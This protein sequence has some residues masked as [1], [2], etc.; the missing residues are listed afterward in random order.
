MEFEFFLE[1]P[2]V[3][4]LSADNKKT[5]VVRHLP[6]HVAQQKCWKNFS[7]RQIAHTT[8]NHVIAVW[9]Y[10]RFWQCLAFSH[11]GHVVFGYDALLSLDQ[12]CSL[13]LDF[14]SF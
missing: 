6:R 9:N 10:G 3:Y 8:N 11:H 14:T 4:L 5:E 13:H 7:Q 1:I 2:R 12:A